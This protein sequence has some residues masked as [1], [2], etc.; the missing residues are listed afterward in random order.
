MKIYYYY[1]KGQQ[2]K[3]MMGPN[4]SLLTAR[5][6]KKLDYLALLPKSYPDLI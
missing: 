6:E 4:Y 1:K 3:E 2:S 5:N